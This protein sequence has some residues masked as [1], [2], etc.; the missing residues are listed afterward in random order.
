[1]NELLLLLAK[2][3]TF[4]K[5]EGSTNRY[6]KELIYAGT[7]EKDGQR[8]SFGLK[9]FSIWLF[10]F[11]ECQKNGVQTFLQLDHNDSPENTRGELMDMELSKTV[12]GL[13]S[14][15]G[16]FQFASEEAEK[17]AT[18][19]QVSVYVVPEFSDGKGN[20]YEGGVI[21]HV[22]LTTT[23]VI[24]A[25]TNFEIAASLSCS[26]KKKEP[27]PMLKKLALELGIEGV[28][29]DATDEA[30]FSKILSHFS[31]LSLALKDFKDRFK[32]KDD[33]DEAAKRKAEDDKKKMSDPI[34][35]SLVNRFASQES[36]TRTFQIDA[37]VKDGR[38]TKA[39]ADD[40]KKD[41]CESK[42][43]ALSFDHKSDGDFKD[44]FSGVLSAL[45]KNERV[46]S[47][48]EKTRDQTYNSE[49]V[50]PLVKDAQ[51]RAD[52]S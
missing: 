27:K 28:T 15:V 21:R 18:N 36:K 29:D 37:L 44:N 49:N 14:L 46:L 16:Y 38:I 5:V 1:M 11:K 17:L 12:E 32:K 4:S 22:A 13:D 24:P 26:P 23:P 48:N 45:E 6:R 2:Q 19:S 3:D 9:E 47:F 34:A 20:K 41:F 30:V 39:V 40:L 25:L 51:E 42:T 52:A 33:E 8:F 10:N 7:F 31:S 50:S 35:A 43:L